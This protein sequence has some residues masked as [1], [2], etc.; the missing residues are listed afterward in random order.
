M[1]ETGLLLVAMGFLILAVTQL[2]VLCLMAGGVWA[3]YSRFILAPKVQEDMSYEELRKVLDSTK[4]PDKELEALDKRLGGMTGIYK[5][6]RD[7]ISGKIRMMP[8]DEA[9]A[10]QE[11]NVKKDMEWEEAWAGDWVDGKTNDYGV[12]VGE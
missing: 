9:E 11:D 6:A 10:I 5:H 12:R 7:P 4:K 2:T 8:I 3:F 1:I